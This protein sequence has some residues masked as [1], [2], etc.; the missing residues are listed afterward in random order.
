MVSKSTIIIIKSNPAKVLE[1]PIGENESKEGTF[2]VFDKGDGDYK[3]YQK[4]T[5]GDLRFITGD[6][7]KVCEFITKNYEMEVD[8]A[9]DIYKDRWQIE[10][11][12]T[13]Y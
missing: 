8:I 9:V 11:M 1:H 6:K 10:T 4:C 7:H 13:N 5:F 12:V 3:Q 2:V